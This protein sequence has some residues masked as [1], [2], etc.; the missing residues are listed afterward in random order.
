[1]ARI[2][3]AESEPDLRKLAED[4]VRELG[5]ELVPA[6]N[7]AAPDLV[8]ATQSGDALRLVRALRA[9]QPRVPIVFLATSEPR[10]ETRA[11]PCAVHVAAPYRLAELRR[12]ITRAL[13]AADHV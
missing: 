11:I 3:V 1:M 9:R 2:V 13:A 7:R 5:H 4:A 12:A 6:S 10:P 8:L